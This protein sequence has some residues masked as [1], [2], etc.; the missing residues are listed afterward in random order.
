MDWIL[1]QENAYIQFGNSNVAIETDEHGDYIM[2]DS[3][4]K[5]YLSRTHTENLKA[6]FSSPPPLAWNY[7]VG[8]AKSYEEGQHEII[9]RLGVEMHRLSVYTQEF[10]QINLMFSRYKDGWK[11][12]RVARENRVFFSDILTH[13]LDVILE[14]PSNRLKWVTGHAEII[15]ADWFYELL[16]K[17]QPYWK[18]K[19]AN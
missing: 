17:Y 4:W 9:F 3:N 8:G 19:K 13:A 7:T 2:D 6:K 10:P 14:I 15:G 1:S 18:V 16:G 11:T 5:N 12:Y